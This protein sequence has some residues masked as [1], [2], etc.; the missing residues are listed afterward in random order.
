MR[1]DQALRH[2]MYV[3]CKLFIY[4]IFSRIQAFKYLIVY[5]T[6]YKHTYGRDVSKY[7][8]KKIQIRTQHLCQP[9]IFS[10]SG[11]VRVKYLKTHRAFVLKRCF[12]KLIHMT[13]FKYFLNGRNRI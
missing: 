4:F 1:A 10:V 8:Y 2:Q 13:Y 11:Y 3:T 9:N 5:F 7:G 12:S 6:V